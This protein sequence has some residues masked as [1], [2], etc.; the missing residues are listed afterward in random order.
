MVQKVS[1][2]FPE[3][4]ETVEFS[5][6]RIIQPKIPEIPGPKLNGK[7]T[8]GK[9]GINREVILFFRN[10]GKC[11][12][13]RYWKL[14]KIQTGFFGKMESSPCSPNFH[15]VFSFSFQTS[16]KYTL[17]LRFIVTYAFL[18]HSKVQYKKNKNVTLTVTFPDGCVAFPV[19]VIL[20]VKE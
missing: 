13:I 18:K 6:M 12:S 15:R 9:L 2:N 1:E 16:V 7:K 20:K 14:P 10:F 5:E 17:S 4:P 8:S 11:C 19:S 3:I